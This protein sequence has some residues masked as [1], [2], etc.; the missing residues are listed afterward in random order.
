MTIGSREYMAGLRKYQQH[1]IESMILEMKVQGGSLEDCSAELHLLADFVRSKA[2]GLKSA[3]P[4][5]LQ[6]T[7]YESR[8]QGQGEAGAAS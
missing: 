7:A 5:L 1:E 6:G 2:D 4:N 3:W 8:E